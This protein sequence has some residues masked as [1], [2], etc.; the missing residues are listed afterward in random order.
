[1][2]RPWLP[3]LLDRS[4]DLSNLPSEEATAVREALETRIE[5]LNLA[6]DALVRLQ[7]GLLLDP[8][9]TR[10]IRMRG[11]TAAA[12]RDRLSKVKA[13]VLCHSLSLEEDRD[14]SLRRRHLARL[15]AFLEHG[16]LQPG[17]AVFPFPGGIGVQFIAPDETRFGRRPLH[18]AL[19]WR[20]DPDLNGTLRRLEEGEVGVIPYLKDHPLDEP[21]AIRSAGFWT[22]VIAERYGVSFSSIRI[23][24]LAPDE[25]LVTLHPPQNT[26]ADLYSLVEALLRGEVGEEA[27]HDP[28]AIRKLRETFGPR[29]RQA[30]TDPGLEEE[31]GKIVPLFPPRDEDPK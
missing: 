14:D 17:S 11:E 20:G 2:E 24:A 10:G 5:T 22:E 6:E 8:V 9:R 31:E 15:L 21:E 12:Y 3:T 13:A 19:V 7:A 26:V 29:S 4:L 16:T 30:P 25:G 23:E 1:M 28:G 27:G 18:W